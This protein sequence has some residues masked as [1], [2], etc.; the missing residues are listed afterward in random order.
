MR[1]DDLAALMEETE[2]ARAALAPLLP[3]SWGPSSMAWML[4]L[5]IEDAVWTIEPG[6]GLYLSIGSLDLRADLVEGDWLLT[7]RCLLGAVDGF[8]RI[9]RDD[10]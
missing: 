3:D 1:D 8:N 10:P 6:V 9:T 4:Q 7:A 2:E 5:E